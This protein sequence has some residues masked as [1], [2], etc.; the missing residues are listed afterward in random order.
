M[1]SRTASLMTSLR[2]L[3]DVTGSQ[4]AKMAAT[5]PEITQI[6]ACR[7]DSNEILTATTMFLRSLDSMMLMPILSD[8]TGSGKSKMAA[9]RPELQRLGL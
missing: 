3:S 6:S 7:Q 8:V 2:I 9:A 4:K 1:F 5:K